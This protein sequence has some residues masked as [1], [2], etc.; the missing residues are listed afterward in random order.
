MLE[1]PLLAHSC[2]L[3]DFLQ[4]NKTACRTMED[5]GLMT[6]CRRMNGDTDINLSGG[7]DSDS[8]E[9]RH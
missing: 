3:D 4:F 1:C 5:S 7:N 6:R 9:T 8:S 2:S